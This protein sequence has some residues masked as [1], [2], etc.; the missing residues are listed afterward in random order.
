MYNDLLHAC[1]SGAVEKVRRLIKEGADVESRDQYGATALM[2]AAYCG[3][4][5]VL[6]LLLEGGASVSASDKDGRT[7]LFAACVNG[8]HTDGRAVAGFRRRCLRSGL[9]RRHSFNGSRILGP[10]RYR[11]ASDRRRLRY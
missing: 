1:S 2:E 10:L 6:E 3:R 8:R 11:D 9:V 4:R 7:A 5:H